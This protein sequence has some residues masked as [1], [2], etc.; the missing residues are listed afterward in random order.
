MGATATASVAILSALTPAI[1]E[2]G[3]STAAGRL[4]IVQAV[5]GDS[6]TVTVDGK[7]VQRNTSEGSVLGPITVSTGRHQVGFDDGSGA[8]R[9]RSTVVVSAGSSSDIVV[10]L[11]AAVHGAPV[12]NSYRTPRSPIGP[13]KARVL[14]AHTATVAPADVRVDGQVAFRNIANG[15]YATADLAAGHHTVALLPTGLTHHPLLGP[16]PVDLKAGTITM[17]YAVGNP[18]DRSMHV[19]AHVATL[20]ADGAVVPTGIDTGAAGLAAD[21]H[22]HPFGARSAQATGTSA[23]LPATGVALAGA[24]LV[25]AGLA[26]GLSW[27]RRHAP[28]TG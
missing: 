5:P 16:L 13:G 10:H 17:V 1:A 12:V 26:L 14:V 18:R 3:A 15:E 8:L 11:P 22:V 19:I 7:T 20:T 25:A 24:A 6:L 27:R 9:L 28:E 21:I 23:D 2:G 4:V